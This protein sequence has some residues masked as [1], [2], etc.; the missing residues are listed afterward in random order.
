MAAVAG[1]GTLVPRALV[2]VT[3]KVYWSPLVRPGT[4]HVSVGPSVPTTVNGQ[5]SRPAPPLLGSFEGEET[6]V[7]VTRYDWVG[8]PSLKAGVQETSAWPLS[9]VGTTFT[10]KSGAPGGM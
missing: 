1:E 10:G 9:D 8:E 7:A 3:E 2:A 4:V 6:S 5:V